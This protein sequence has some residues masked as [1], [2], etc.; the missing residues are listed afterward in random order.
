MVETIK[1]K[2]IVAEKDRVKAKPSLDDIS[3]K[4][5][6]AIIKKYGQ[7]AYDSLVKFDEHMNKVRRDNDVALEAL[8]ISTN[9]ED[10]KAKI[11]ELENMK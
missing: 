10:I 5:K 9:I 3:L 7:K 6:Y 8:G 1:S 11:K 4:T 2:I